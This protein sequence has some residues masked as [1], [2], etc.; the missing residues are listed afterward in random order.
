MHL[1]QGNSTAAY[2]YEETVVGGIILVISLY[3]CYIGHILIW[4]FLLSLDASDE[5]GF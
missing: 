5:G 1:L 4:M 2:F 3:G